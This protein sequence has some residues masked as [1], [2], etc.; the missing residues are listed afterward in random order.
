MQPPASPLGP[1]L[2]RE[3]A[4]IRFNDRVLSLV[5]D[6]TVPLLERIRFLSIFQSNLD[7]FFMKRIGILRRRIA[8]PGVFRSRDGMTATEQFLAIRGMVQEM[9]KRA[10]LLFSS[11]LR[12]ELNQQGIQLLDWASLTLEEQAFAC[13]YFLEA[14]FPTLTP[15]SVDPGHPFPFISNQS[16]SFAIR[17]QHPDREENLFSRVKIPELFP[18]WVDLAP[19]PSPAPGPTR[20]VSILDIVSNNLSLLFPEMKILGFMAFRVTRNMEIERDEENVDDLLEMIEQELRERKFGEV[21]K[22]EHGPRPDP[23]LLEFLHKELETTED[24][25]YELAHY[26]DFSN[27]SALEQLKRPDLKYPIWNPVNPIEL[28]DDAADLFQLLSTK[29]LLTHHPYES[30]SSSVEKLI[31]TAALDPNVLAIKM[32]LYRTQENSPIVESLIQAAESGKQVAC[33]VELKA[34]FEEQRNVQWAKKMEDSGVHVVYGVVGLKTHCKVLLIV[35]KEGPGLRCYA[36]TGTGNYNNQTARCYTDLGL[37]TS[38]PEIT[39]EILEVFNYLTGRSLKRSYNQ[40][41]VSPI[42][43]KSQLLAQIEKETVIARSGQPARI[44]FKCNNLEDSDVCHALY[45]ASEAGVEID[46]IV[47]SICTLRPGVPGLSEKIRVLSVVDRFLEHSRLYYFSRGESKPENGSFYLGSADL[48]SRSFMGRVE[49]LAPV[50][51]SNLR[52]RCYEILSIFLS[53]SAQSWR[54]LSDGNYERLLP[55]EGSDPLS[56]QQALMNLVKKQFVDR[57]MMEEAIRSLPRVSH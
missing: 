43:L 29:D 15:L 3:I 52:R 57:E 7:E 11:D 41:W 48:M 23:W 17:I 25:T 35:R 44:I 30:F 31:H 2:N 50:H 20:R 22:L 54:M 53:H 10:D 19:T 27:L 36:H 24:D 9:L 14:V 51:D 21:V 38:R 28:G 16:L 13:R 47:R 8:S 33:L 55:S 45:R 34:R 46:L 32:A 40:L 12:P 4:W 26:L 39:N 56:A 49:V 42:H 6:P 37:M 18:F 1:L 5:A